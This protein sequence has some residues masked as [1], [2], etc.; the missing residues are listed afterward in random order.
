M[1]AGGASTALLA[2]L[3][4]PANASTLTVDSLGDGVAD[5]SH[6]TDG[7]AGNC[8]L[9]DAVT[10]A[11]SGDTIDFGGLTGTIT[12]TAGAIETSGS[13]SIAGP[14]SSNLTISGG[15]S[16]YIFVTQQSGDV[17]ISGLTITDAGSSTYPYSYEGGAI[18]FHNSGSATVSDVV[19]SNS[20]AYYGGGVFFANAG[21]ATIS[22]S[23]FSG[24]SARR[25]AAVYFSNGGSSGATRTVTSS[26]FV[27]N[28][29]DQGAGIFS[30]T[31]SP[32]AL[33]VTSCTF[34]GN[35]T[36]RFD[37]GGSGGAGVF[38][39]G[40]AT[41]NNSTFSGNS[42]KSGG[43]AIVSSGA[44][45]INDSTISANTNTA[46]N[47]GSTAGRSGAIQIRGGSLTLVG[48]IVSGNTANVAGHADVALY[49]PGSGSITADD[50]LLGEVGSPLTVNGSNNVTST[51][52]LLDSLADNGGPTKTMALLSGS[53]AID[54]GPS[55]VPTFT[56]NQFDQRGTGYPRTN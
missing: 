40:P 44:L 29:G 37:D 13:L 36:T 39:Q 41:I 3:A 55:V 7:V 20:T 48:T 8:T 16:T 17:S 45:V 27:G 52:P 51:S 21:S 42:S 31:D 14:G 26:T 30:D 4:S 18:F 28:T 46:D 34:S 32:Y 5:A 11:S 6:C 22:N 54:A 23:V 10:A 19:V 56:G 43:P 53:P 24:N 15:N 25:G 38:T 47:P 12:V 1:V 9:R 50:S 2:V 49:G 33:V 35:L